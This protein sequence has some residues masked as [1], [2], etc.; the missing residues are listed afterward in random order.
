M[1]GFDVWYCLNLDGLGLIC[2]FVWRVRD[3]RASLL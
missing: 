2:V 1:D 3:I